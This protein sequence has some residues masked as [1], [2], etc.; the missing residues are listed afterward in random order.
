MSILNQDSGD[1]SALRR[2]K[3]TVRRKIAICLRNRTVW[4]IRR[5]GVS[6]AS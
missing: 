3:T 6:Y 5:V 2:E 1:D 4:R